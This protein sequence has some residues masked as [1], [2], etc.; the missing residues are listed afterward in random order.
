MAHDNT[1]GCCLS[2][3]SHTPVV[4]QTA[5]C[6]LFF[7]L[8]RIFI[9]AEELTAEALKDGWF[10]TGDIGQIDNDGY[11]KITDRKKDI[12][13]NSSGKNIAPQKVENVLKTIP[14]IS[15]SIVFGDRVKSLVALLTM[16]EQATCDFARVKNWAFKDYACLLASSELHEYLKDE[17]HKSSSQLANHERVF[18]FAILP[19]ELSVEAG[20]LTATLKV[21]RSVLKDKYRDLIESL[22]KEES[23]LQASAR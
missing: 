14:L 15:Q 12:I 1:A 5:A 9:K 8:T 13:V 11:L 3:K 19:Q 10:H 20:E 16:D 22:H 17:I 2:S 21:K 23:V 6:S 7:S 18:N 4:L